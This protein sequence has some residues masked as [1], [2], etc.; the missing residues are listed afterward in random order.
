MRIKILITRLL[1]RSIQDSLYYTQNIRLCCIRAHV[2][3]LGNEKADELAKEAITSSSAKQDLKQRELA[4]WQ[5]RWDDGI[6]GCS[7]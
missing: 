1:A 5:S 7:S 3:H 4:K 6:N 2:G